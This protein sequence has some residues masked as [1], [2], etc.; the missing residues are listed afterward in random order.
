M[1]P[2]ICRLTT[3]P[4]IHSAYSSG[5][6]HIKSKDD[7]LILVSAYC[8]VSLAIGRLT[9]NSIIRTAYSSGTYHLKSEEVYGGL[10][11]EVL[12]PAVSGEKVMVRGDVLYP[13]LST[14]DQA[15]TV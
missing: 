10:V 11:Q 5:T 9:T 4:I 2:V 15:R 6:Y 13:L 1:A 3:D 7:L 12:G 14:V 8:L